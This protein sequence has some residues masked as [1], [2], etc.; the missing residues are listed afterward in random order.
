MDLIGKRYLNEPMGAETGVVKRTRD[1]IE[2][3]ISFFHFGRNLVI[4]K[5]VDMDVAK[6]VQETQLKLFRNI[7]QDVRSRNKK[8]KISQPVSHN[9]N[10]V[11]SCNSTIQK[12]NLML[13]YH[14]KKCIKK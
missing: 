4:N 8:Q 1:E 9:N 14:N 7:E 3:T 2:D 13:I 11:M 10:E 6:R 5:D 12:M